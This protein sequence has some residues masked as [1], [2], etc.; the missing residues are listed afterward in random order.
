MR[1]L[2][3]LLGICIL[4]MAM[5]I[6]VNAE[7]GTAYSDGQTGGSIYYTVNGDTVSITDCDVSVTEAIVP[8]T[9]EGLPVTV[10]EAN[11]FRDCSVL[12]TV[13]LPRSVTTIN[14]YAFY[15]CSNLVSVYS[16]SE[17]TLTLPNNTF[18]RT[19]LFKY[20][21]VDNTYTEITSYSFYTLPS[22]PKTVTIPDTI[23]GLPVQAISQT[24][25]ESCQFEEL[26]L[27][28]TLV[29]CGS[30]KS[31]SLKRITIPDSVT[32]TANLSFQ[33]CSS[34]EYVKLP[35]GITKINNSMF[36]GC[37]KLS[38]EIPDTIE[39]IGIYAFFGCDSLEEVIIPERV[40]TIGNDA[41]R[42]CLGLQSVT[43]PSSVTAIPKQCFYNC[44]VLATVN[45]P[46]TLE[47][48]GNSAFS[49]CLSLTS[50]SFTLP[51]GL[52]EIGDMA[53]LDCSSLTAIELP[54]TL[55]KINASAFSKTGL[56]S[57]EIPPLITTI[58]SDLFADCTSLV[59][60]DIPE[61]VTKI[62][63]RAF[64]NCTVLSSKDTLFPESL[65]DIANNSFQNC[66]SLTGDLTLPNNIRFVRNYAFDGCT[67]LTSITFPTSPL[68]IGTDVC[69]GCINLETVY[70]PEGS[71]Y[72]QWDYATTISK[73]FE[74]TTE[75]IVFDMTLPALTITPILNSE[76]H[77]RSVNLDVSETESKIE[78]IYVA[79]GEY[80]NADDLI[81]NGTRRYYGV[82]QT[83]AYSDLAVN[84][85]RG[86]YTVGVMNNAGGWLFKTIDST[87]IDVIVPL[88]LEA[89]F[90]SCDNG[91]FF[92][93]IQNKSSG[94]VSISCNISALDDT[95]I[96]SDDYFDDWSTINAEQTNKYL[97]FGFRTD[98]AT[99]WQIGKDDFISIPDIAQN[100]TIKV[101]IDV[102][103]GETV[104][105]EKTYS[106]SFNLKISLV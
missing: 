91:E 14:E 23:D 89:D 56:V 31:S 72:S 61:G 92:C 49:G 9:I 86:V 60:V 2:I 6:S 53:F 103:H 52:T 65:I 35:A 76:G 57:V 37:K 36:Q 63:N 64:Q 45:F 4:F 62:G 7:T 8:S 21:V 5:P 13:M 22:L 70:I 43:I 82:D 104:V 42:N 69:K 94:A 98:G 33:S 81:A 105:T 85:P 54:D 99:D 1:K 73:R 3:S 51:E 50:S 18:Q 106:L 71:F 44:S 16:P 48:I 90:T 41:F 59:S 87:F 19:Y 95:E 47:T 24:A 75:V 88:S 40:T 17:V 101:Y 58:E 20:I 84:E 77:I 25:F 27:P 68:D 67:G 96:V 79:Y 97:A 32:D 46:D 102:L 12:E 15:G 55:T 80:D 100:D 74:E 10:V 34:L 26:V 29:S 30:F 28:D 83:A 38:F 11:A 78:A 39:E 66:S 93:D